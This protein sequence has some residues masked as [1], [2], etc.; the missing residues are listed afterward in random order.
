[1]SASFYDLMK[2]AHTGLATADMTAYDKMRALA[3]AGGK[4]KTLTGVPPLS[5]TGNGKPLISWSM[6]GNSQQNGTPAPDA[7]IM[8]GFVG[9]RTANLFDW[10][11]VATGYRITW[12]TG[13]LIEDATAIMSDFIQVSRGVCR[14]NASF[15]M[16]GYDSS[17]VY[18]GTYNPSTTEFKK[19]FGNNTTYF[20]IPSKVT[21][22]RLLSFS[23][24]IGTL[25]SSTMFNTG[26]TSLP[27][28]PYGWKIPVTSAGQTVP[29]YLGQVQTT[30]RIKKLVLTGEENWVLE[31][32]DH[33]YIDNMMPG[34][35]R[36]ML[37]ICTHQQSI[38]PN[39]NARENVYIS[40]SCRLNFTTQMITHT[41]EAFTDWLKS[42]Y[43]VGTPVT[44]WYVLAEPETAIINEP[45]AKIGTYADELHS[46]DAGVSIPTA[47]GS[48]T[49]TVETD[50]KP[51]EMTITYRG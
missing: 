15:I 26:L 23:R 18:V 30:R 22:V 20:N 1:M 29:I 9:E 28:E 44:V 34:A 48:N 3:M 45:L 47:R 25:S 2:Y 21:F 24:T 19:E 10:S 7:P 40:G 13:E 38:V 49:L 27:Y 42:Q 11:A 35:K 37:V 16:L 14:T 36:S 4:V 31:Y 32:D 39:H 33:F 12:N 17:K 8:P 5:F 46:A 6:L 41:I 51:S 50:L 43:S